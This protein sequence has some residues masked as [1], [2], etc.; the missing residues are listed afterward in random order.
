VYRERYNG[1]WRVCID[2]MR[3]LCGF[4]FYNSEIIRLYVCFSPQHGQTGSDDF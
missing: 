3:G 1:L 4:G 2:V